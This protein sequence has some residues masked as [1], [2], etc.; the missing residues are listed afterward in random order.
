[1]SQEGSFLFHPTAGN[2]Y[3]YSAQQDH[4]RKRR[5]APAFGHG[6]IVRPVPAK[7]EGETLK[8]KG[9]NEQ[10][11]LN[12]DNLEALWVKFPPLRCTGESVT[13]TVAN[14]L[15]SASHR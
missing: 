8:C 12:L 13:P 2:D 4:Y 7:M 10:S 14:G 11:N 6:G 15:Q 5:K 9:G 3:G 1:M